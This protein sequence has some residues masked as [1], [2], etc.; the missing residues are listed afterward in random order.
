MNKMVSTLMIGS[1]LALSAA[2]SS[3]NDRRRAGTPD[4]FRVVKKAPLTV[5]PEYSLR[6]PEISTVRPQEVSP[7]RTDQIISF[8][9]GIGDDASDVEKM[10]VARAGAIAVSPVI[11]DII[12]YDE[13]GLLRKRRSVSDV[14]TGYTGNEEELAAAAEDNATGG[15]KVTIERGNGRRIKLPGT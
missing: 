15:E 13:S 3:T 1:V 9:N 10:L 14:V 2:C 7:Q 6:P 8:G 5:P 11:R 4:E 12:D